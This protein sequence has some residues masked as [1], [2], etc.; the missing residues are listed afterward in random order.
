MLHLDHRDSRDVDL[1]LGDP[2]YITFFSPRLNATAE[3][4]TTNYVEQSNFLKLSFPE[5][6]IDFV[7]A[8]NLTPDPT[9]TMPLE[10]RAIR[11]ER[12][13]EILA[14]KVFYRADQLRARDVFDIACVLRREPAVFREIGAFV[15]PK[16][17]ALRARLAHPPRH[18]LDDF[19][20]LAGR[21]DF[22]ELTW[23][24][25]SGLVLAALREYRPPAAPSD[26][27]R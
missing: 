12:P 9:V 13:A 6:E 8:P 3:S 4:L 2:H 21:G 22:A 26:P 14:K 18:L 15:A 16:A 1:F 5:G 7:V 17:D 11:V 23:A 24:D 25:A 10:G 19:R 20:M 27:S